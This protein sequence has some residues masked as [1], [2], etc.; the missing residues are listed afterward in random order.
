MKIPDSEKGSKYLAKFMVFVQII[1]VAGAIH[2]NDRKPW[3]IHVSKCQP[4]VNLERRHFQG[5]LFQTYKANI[6]WILAYTRFCEGSIT[7]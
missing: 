1:Y 7:Y 3:K 5:E 4:E 2:S 6:F